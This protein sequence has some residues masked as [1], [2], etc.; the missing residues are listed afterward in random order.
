METKSVTSSLREYCKKH[1][2]EVFDVELMNRSY[3]ETTPSA[4]RK[5][6]SRL[7]EEGILTP[8]S[9]GVYVIGND[10][11]QDDIYRVVK[12]HYIYPFD[13]PLKES[14]L[15]ELGIIDEKPEIETYSK[16]WP[17]G[18]RNILNLRI[19][20]GKNTSLR[21]A[22]CREKVILLD[23]I[24]AEKCV[25]DDEEIKMNYSVKLAEMLLNYKEV[26]YIF[27]PE[28]EYSRIIYIKLANLLDS[29]HISNRVIEYY[30]NK[31]KDTNR[32]K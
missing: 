20:E 21:E 6:V 30:E 7:V 19:V 5:F 18:N 1:P 12:K 22:G 28:I 15:Y 27:E 4:F 29:M 25:P 3:P 24:D 16:I 23:L 31:L 9:K 14:L 32:Q 10:L 17:R 13:R 11:S 2:R 26:D 8:A